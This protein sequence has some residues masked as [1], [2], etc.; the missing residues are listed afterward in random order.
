MI[1]KIDNN[2]KISEALNGLENIV[3]AIKEANIVGD[4]YFLMLTTML[5]DTVDEFRFSV[6]Y[7][8][9]KTNLP[10]FNQ[11]RNECLRAVFSVSKGFEFFPDEDIKKAADVFLNTLNKYSLSMIKENYATESTRIKKMLADFESDEL[12]NAIAKLNPLSELIENLKNA[13][14]Q[15]DNAV[16]CWSD[17]NKEDNQI[18]SSYSLKME[19]LSILNQKLIPYLNIVVCLDEDL[20]GNISGIIN[21]LVIKTNRLAK[22]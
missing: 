17:S 15:F 7:R 19:S 8:R 6:N 4:K 1:K 20:F 18:K 22:N 16:Q 12:K 21:N 11:N 10:E 5:K 14:K 2:I 13:Q 9:T 3:I